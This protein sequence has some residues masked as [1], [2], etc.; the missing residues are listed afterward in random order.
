MDFDEIFE[1][2][3]AE[4]KVFKGRGV[5]GCRL[6]EAYVISI[7]TSRLSSLEAQTS[8]LRCRCICIGRGP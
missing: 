2:F 5:S 3:L 8:P 6:G 7:P 1:S 4:A